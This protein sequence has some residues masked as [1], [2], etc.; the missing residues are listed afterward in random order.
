MGIST[1]SKFK[2]SLLAVIA[3]TLA[4]GCTEDAKFPE[5]VPPK[6]ET[7]LLVSDV[8]LPRSGITLRADQTEIVIQGQG[9][10]ATDKIYAG[11]GVSI[12]FEVLSA[13]E[14]SVTCRLPQIESGSYTLRVERGE[15]R[16]TLGTVTITILPY[17]TLIAEGD[18]TIMG[19]V[20]CDGEP[21][22][23]VAISDGIDI[24][25]TDDNG[26]YRIESDKR[27][28]LV[29]V[30][31]P[32]GYK[33]LTEGA[34]I[35]FYQHTVEPADKAEQIDF[36]LEK[37]TSTRFD[38]LLMADIHLAART[39]DYEQFTTGFALDVNIHAGTLAAAGGE[40]LGIDLGDLSWDGYWY[41]NDFAIDDAKRVFNEEVG[42]PT[43]HVIGNHD[44]DPYYADD[45]A[46]EGAYRREL[47]PTYY[48]FNLGD[49][50]VVV[51][52]NTVYL[53]DGGDIGTVG[54]RNYDKYIT[55]AQGTWLQKDLAMV[56]DKTKPLIIALHCPAIAA[57]GWDGNTIE[58]A[59]AFS[60]ADKISDMV[61]ALAPFSNVHLLSGHEHENSTLRYGSNI[62]SHTVAAIS[63]T[64]WWTGYLNNGHI[65]RDG[66]PG[67]YK[68]FTI[69]GDEVSWYY[70]GIGE[71]VDYQMR[72]YDL[73]T[74]PAEYGGVPNS[75]MVAIN[76]WDYD[77]EWTIEVT[78]SGNPLTVTPI[79]AKD[80]LH[81]IAYTG[82]TS[83]FKSA[84]NH[85]IFAV[86]ATSADADI[87]ITAT[88][89]DGVVYSEVMKRPKPFSVTMK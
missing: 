19:Y 50:H 45:F 26:I 60:P 67:G 47:G 29:F 42:V 81:Q 72:S 59:S 83:T 64:W 30:S 17:G 75:N 9:F 33:H 63:A 78:E 37:S 57:T 62:T 61:T 8:Q 6:G 88:N 70:K 46:S 38:L 84:N 2:L 10:E 28:S 24:V 22:A 34:N 12:E 53:N 41:S 58:I 39:N 43:Y 49:A 82:N 3:L 52:D 74:V 32:K 77:T 36:L 80:P 1:K 11:E 54:D 14:V 73:N 4:V 20:Y 48:S 40:V 25:T 89:G 13:N 56:A 51:L 16:Q 15:N 79:W 85:H 65:C 68:V 76:V 86:Q 23:G 35:N 66:S 44:H 7:T 21:V 18:E 69:N 87:T 5:F 27:H 71:D 31:T 55:D